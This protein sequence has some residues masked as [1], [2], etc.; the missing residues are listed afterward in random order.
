M[1]SGATVKVEVA[2][3]VSHLSVAVNVT[4]TVPPSHALGACDAPELIDGSHPPLTL[5]LST[6]AA[7]AASIA[8]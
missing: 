1:L 7:N 3:P 2:L 5:A 6:H 8:D 4:V